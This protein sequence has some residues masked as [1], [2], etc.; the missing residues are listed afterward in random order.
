ML[1]LCGPLMVTVPSNFS[2]GDCHLVTANANGTVYVLRLNE[3]AGKK[4]E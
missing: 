4:K 3:W 2:S 1:N